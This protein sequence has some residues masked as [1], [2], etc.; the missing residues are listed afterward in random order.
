[1]SSH[2]ELTYFDT[3]GLAEVIRLL[4]SFLDVDY[5]EKNI[6]SR[7]EWLALK[8][9]LPYGQVPLLTVNG[10]RMVQRKAIEKYICTKHHLY[11]KDADE[12]YEID[13][14]NESV[15]DF[16]NA[17]PMRDIL[18][19][20]PS[21]EEKAS[22]FEKSSMKWYLNIWNEM[23]TKRSPHTHLVGDGITYADITLFSALRTFRQIP[24][25]S[26]SLDEY[27]SLV[28]FYDHVATQP[29]IAK[30]LTSH[31]SYPFP[32]SKEYTTKIRSILY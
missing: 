8:P 23:L 24:R 2:V 29:T 31:K 30:Y 21:A 27:F 10:K 14:I 5:A 25:F 3:R 18:S 28:K 1:M 32:P 9:S 20:D 11:G 16:T 4:L 7:E 12:A 26:H 19:E 22:A 15:A 17:L 13:S 6:S